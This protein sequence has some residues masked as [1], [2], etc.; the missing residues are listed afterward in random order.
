MSV[1]TILITGA[2][3]GIGAAL[4]VTYAGPGVHLVLWGRDD[5]RLEQ[6]ATTCRARG[7]LAKTASFDLC[8]IAL[9]I[10]HLERADAETHIDLAIF[11]AG[12][13]GSIP[14]RE[15]AQEARAAFQMASV[16]FTAPAVGANVV[17]GR[18]AQRGKGHIVLLGSIAGAFPLPMA[19]LYSGSKAGLALFAEALRLRLA[20]NGVRVTLVEPGFVDT[21]MSRSLTEPKPFLIGADAA[22]KVIVAGIE[23]G[24]RR[25]V[26]PWQFALIRA[27][28]GLVPRAIVRAVLSQ[29]LR[30]SSAE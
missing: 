1:K 19:P 28:A 10:E 8:D 6:T 14:P 30:K 21:P 13:G 16:N 11:N 12:I 23:R 25:I 7:A 9:L 18:M 2:S 27:A 4:A 29:V 17:A 15:A 24:R 26:V 22:V 3:S 5:E 20:R